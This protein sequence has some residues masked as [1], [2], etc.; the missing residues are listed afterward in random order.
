MYCTNS[1]TMRYLSTVFLIIILLYGCSSSKAIK[2]SDFP[3]EKGTTWVYTY[4]A[5]DPSPSDPE[6]VIHAT[7][8]LTDTVIDAETTSNYLV[9]HVKRDWKLLTADPDWTWDMSSQPREFWYVRDG[10]RV[11]QSNMPIDTSNIKPDELIL[12]Y[13]FPLSLKSGWCLLPDARKDSRGTAGCDF[14]GRR[15]VTGKGSYD[16]PVGSFE[17]CYDIVDIYNGGN[18]LQKFCDGAGSVF[19]KFDHAGTKFG[20]EQTLTDL[21]HKCAI[22][23]A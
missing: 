19:M 8:Q 16:T 15:Q 1:L 20:F 9:A 4:E 21:L 17:N 7:Y 3:L 18:I 11:Y 6:Q 2:A 23:G 12:A 10:Q 14:V 22:I 5:Y 13:E